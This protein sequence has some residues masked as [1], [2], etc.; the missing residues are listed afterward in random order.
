MSFA[1]D[2][3]KI[4]K[5]S[6]KVGMPLHNIDWDKEM[7][8][9]VYVKMG[10]KIRHPYPDPNKGAATEAKFFDKK[11]RKKKRKIVQDGLQ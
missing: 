8:T 3:K 11:Y 5:L 7:I 2:M 10:R 4:E 1:Q 6:R 9:F